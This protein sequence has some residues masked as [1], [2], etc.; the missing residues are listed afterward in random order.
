MRYTNMTYACVDGLRDVLAEGKLLSW[1]GCKVRE[2]SNRLT[3]VERPQERCLV[4]PSR[5]NNIFATIAETM[6]ILAGRNDLAFL[7]RYLPRAQDFSDDGQ[8]WRAAYGP[9][10]RNWHGVDQL[11]ENLTLMRHELSTRRAVMS[12][13][14]PAVDF[15]DSKDIPCNNWIHWL[16]RDDR[17]HINVPVRSNDLICGFS[18]LNSF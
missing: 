10:L 12:I 13:F 16:V 17:L 2:L 14:D 9:R 15:I 5:H 7:S 1:G 11:R 18:C 4:T 8:T 6:W 3:V